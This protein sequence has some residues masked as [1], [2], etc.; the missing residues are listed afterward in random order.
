MSTTI[1]LKRSNTPSSI[2]S[3]TALA[4][5]ELAVNTNDGVLYFKISPSGLADSIVALQPIG[6]GTGLVVGDTNATIN[7]PTINN[8]VFQQTL[9]IGTQIF[10]PHTNGFSVNENFDIT[11]PSQDPAYQA[12]FTGYHFTSGA[13]KDGVAFT[14]ARSGNFTD[15]F[16]I[17][18]DAYNNNFVIGSETSNT[19][20]VFKTGIG[21]PFN[22][23]GGTTIFTIT[24]NGTL[25]LSNG[26]TIQDLPD[27]GSPQGLF[28]TVNSN[29]TQ[30]DTGG[31]T[32][33][34]NDLVI[35]YG[36]ISFPNSSYQT[37]AWLGSVSQ[38]VNNTVTLT[39]NSDGSVQFPY[40]TFPAT[41]GL[42]GQILTATNTGVQWQYAG[43][44]GTPTP[45]K[46]FN[47][48][49][50][51][52]GFL[53]GTAQFIPLAADAIKTIVLVNAYAVSQDLVLALYRNNTFVSYFTLPAGRYTYKYNS[54]NILIN[55]NESYTVN[56]VSGY[57]NSLS[58]SLYNIIL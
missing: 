55:T 30:F 52:S 28:L 17:T 36:G 39:L 53:A 10:Y 51:F 29:V 56:V 44:G 12:N 40:Y 6:T 46:T 58:M 32:H 38:L 11:D 25:T 20:Y 41:S 21:M 49:G 26:S 33:F 54:L 18:G 24:R 42:P 19:D 35:N 4:D 27:E 9:S 13:G 34:P 7:S 1:Q 31:R 45:V 48:L 15:G 3:T 47:I 16:G 22:V 57:G 14:L 5:G 37:T 8:A 43:G 2:P 23:S 50:N